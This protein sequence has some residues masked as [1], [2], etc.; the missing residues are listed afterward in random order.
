[1]AGAMGSICL[2]YLDINI[3]M[4]IFTTEIWRHNKKKEERNKKDNLIYEINLG[5]KTINR[6]ID[7][8]TADMHTVP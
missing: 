1:M 2:Y 6:E 4:F 7:D 8:T 3:G 5:I